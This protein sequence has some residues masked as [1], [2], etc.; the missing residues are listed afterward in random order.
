RERWT[1]D[2]S[3]GLAGE[4]PSLARADPSAAEYQHYRPREVVQERDHDDAPRRTAAVRSRCGGG[5]V[6]VR[7]QLRCLA[8]EVPGGLR[9][10]SRHARPKG[11][12]TLGICD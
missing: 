4:S 8:V 12:R 5:A 2:D 11:A 6:A 7:S 9:E 10:R 1:H 3:L